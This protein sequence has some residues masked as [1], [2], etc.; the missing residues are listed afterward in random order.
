MNL[1]QGK[2]QCIECKSKKVIKDY[3]R[4]EVYCSKCGLILVDNSIST[5]QQKINQSKQKEKETK[6]Q[7]TKKIQYWRLK[8]FFYNFY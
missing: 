7:K 2:I 3:E 5:L 1:L 6:N 4:Q 8:N